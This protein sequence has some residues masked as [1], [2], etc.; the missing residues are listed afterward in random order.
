MPLKELR[1]K[2]VQEAPQLQQQASAVIKEVQEPFIAD[3]ER[4]GKVEHKVDPKRVAV[5]VV[6]IPKEC[7]IPAG[8]SV[9][10][11]Y[12]VHKLLWYK[13]HIIKTGI[14]AFDYESDGDPGDRLQK[15][16]EQRVVGVSF[17]CEVGTAVYL[18]IGH[19][20]YSA[21]W[22]MEWLVANFLKPVLEHP[23]V[24]VIAHHIG[25]EY[26]LSILHGVDLYPKSRKQMVMDTMYMLKC[27]MPNELTNPYTGEV[28]LG[29]KPA[30]KALLAD[31][32]GV[33]HGLLDVENILDFKE[34]VGYREELRPTGKLTKTG[35]PEMRKTK[36]YRTFNMLPVEQHVIDY[37]CS[38][39]DWTLGL[40]YKMKAMIDADKD[41]ESLWTLLYE[42]NIPFAMIMAEVTM[43][44]WRTNED[45]MEAYRKKA[46]DMLYGY[47]DEN[48]QWVR[49]LEDEL[50]EE[51][52]NLLIEKKIPVQFAE[53]GMP[54]VLKGDYYMGEPTSGKYKGQ[55]VVLTISKDGE[56][57]WASPQ[58]L[59]WL[60]Y[61]VLKFEPNKR[62]KDTGL[63]S[64][65]S[66]TLD[67]LIEK[68]G[69]DSQFMK[70]LKKKRKYDKLLSTYVE[71]YKKVMRM[72]SRLHAVLK[73]VDTWRLSAS[74]PN[75]QNIPR[76]SNDELGIRKMMEAP[77]YDV[78]SPDKY[79]VWNP[80]MRPPAVIFKNRLSGK[81][82]YI[83]ADYS[84]IELRVL[85]VMADEP[86]MLYAFRNGIDIHSQTAKDVNNL[87]CEVH[88]V[89][90]KY[91]DLRSGAK[92]VNFGIV[93]GISEFGLA[94][95]PDMKGRYTVAQC[96]EFIR[97]YKQ[98]YSRI[99]NYMVEQIT[100]ARKHK[101]IVDLFGHR[102]ALPGINN[103]WGNTRAQFE[104]KAMNTPIQS[105]ASQ[106]LR[107][108]MVAIRDEAPKRFPKGVF[109][110]VMPIHDDLISEVPIEYAV[111]A[112]AFQKEMQ[113]QEI[114]G[115]T[116]GT[117]S[118]VPISVDPA[119]GVTWGRSLEVKYEGDK[120]YA[121]I[122]KDYGYKAFE[123]YEHELETIQEAGF[124]LREV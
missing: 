30:T 4:Y 47:E 123:G 3:R 52:R 77:T 83:S 85:A 70:V 74:V 45:T 33:V 21:N 34:T 11:K 103:P 118:W 81:T 37:A 113:E 6:E 35:K 2:R 32:K 40:Y 50:K 104:R 89:K 79:R 39:S 46:Q 122:N 36:I 9:I 124:I 117:P 109:K 16:F 57:S 55:G 121:E 42:L 68:Y 107:L 71:G 31:E 87:D 91:K 114:E 105:S 20:S 38:D 62:S 63:P 8:Y 18:P 94:N 58:K 115:V 53:S 106:I 69:D 75:L 48:G 92:A 22:D 86:N 43:T 7:P 19:D 98:K 28:T 12:E 56:F 90:K 25:V 120:A 88:E 44:G 59:Q 93:Y 72:D 80:F 101:F 26:T 100:F 13:E 112:L 66:E 60:Y 61:H 65:D 78:T 116:C 95:H 64:T 51:L 27:M 5:P 54:I 96:A 110:M 41:A 49:G 97:R 14:V 15:T 67:E 24:Y 10:N 23:D 102:R 73:V 108:G 17:C 82:V 119:V 1:N 111:E 84:Q 29:L 76:A 99:E